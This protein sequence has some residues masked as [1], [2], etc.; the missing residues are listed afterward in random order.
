MSKM[1][2]RR[3]EGSTANFDVHYD[4]SLGANGQ[5]LANA[6]LANC[7]ADLFALRGWFGGADPGH[8]SV[9]TD[10]AT[11]GPHHAT[12]AVTEIRR[13]AFDGF[14]CASSWLNSARSD[15]VTNTAGTDR[16]YVLIGC[17][18][19]FLNYLRYQLHISLAR[20]VQVGGLTLQHAYQHLTNSA[21]AFGSFVAPLRRHFPAGIQ[22]N[23]PDDNPFLL[24]DP[25][26]WG[27]WESLGGVGNCDGMC[28]GGPHDSR[29]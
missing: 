24:L 9:Y 27:G 19:P 20:I 13:A 5:N 29:A 11:F 3:G 25:A 16:D 23:L 21:D 2:R 14:A 18:T 12:S 28:H 4:D 7:E 26:V 1:L 15:W 22:V 17:A 8:L 10:P 6:V